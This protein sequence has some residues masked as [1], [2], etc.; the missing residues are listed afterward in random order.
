MAEET[1]HVF[2]SEFYKFPLFPPKQTMKSPLRISKLEGAD[3]N[4]S[5][6][7]GFM[8]MSASLGCA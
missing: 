7:L 2:G 4:A 1:F 5:L 6:G 8:F 3:N